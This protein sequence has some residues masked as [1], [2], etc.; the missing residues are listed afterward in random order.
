MGMRRGDTA[1]RDELDRVIVRR[2]G[3][4]RRVLDE[5][6]VPL[7]DAAASQAARGTP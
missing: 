3:E 7:V 6:G 1:L 5:F 4:I 2:A